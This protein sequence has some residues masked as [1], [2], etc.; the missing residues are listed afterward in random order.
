L[1]VVKIVMTV[2]KKLVKIWGDKVVAAEKAE[3]TLDGK[4]FFEA[5]KQH[6]Q[7]PTIESFEATSAKMPDVSYYQYMSPSEYWAVNAEP[8]MKQVNAVIP[9]GPISL[10][11][12]A[13]M[14]KYIRHGLCT[15]QRYT[16]L[17]TCY[18]SCN[19]THEKDCYF[20]VVNTMGATTFISSQIM[21]R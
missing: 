1:T 13:P 20:P 3:K 8:L 18:N 15:L 14:R 2:K 5:L 10:S 9:V 16:S 12:G 4:Q 17:P 7:N 11:I 21:T 19:A 6:L